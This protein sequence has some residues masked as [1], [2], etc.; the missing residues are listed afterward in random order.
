MVATGKNDL[1]QA[2]GIPGQNS[3]PDVISAE[4]FVIQ[5]ALEYGKFPTLMVK[6][7]KRLTEL[8]EAGVRCF[9]ISRDETLLAAAMKNTLK[10]MKE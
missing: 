6:G 7:K 8:Q 5:K 4:N 2:L 10:E 9:T 1:S 3:H